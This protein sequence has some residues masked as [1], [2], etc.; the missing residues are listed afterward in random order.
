[1]ALAAL[2][3]YPAERLLMS[4]HPVHPKPVILPAP[5][6]A[7]GVFAFNDDFNG[8]DGMPPDPAHWAYDIGPGA[9]V[10]GNHE[11]ETYTSSTANAYQD[12][13]SHL[14]IAVTADGSGGTDSARIK[15]LGKYTQLHGSWQ[16]SIAIE[17]TPGCWP[18]FWL[19][20]ANGQWPACGEADVMENYGSGFTEG[21]IW[22]S[23]ATQ[24]A[25]GRALTAVDRGFHT[26]Q[27]DSSPGKITY[28]VD[29]TAYAQATSATVRPWP[30][31]GNG[32]LY[33]ILNVAVNGTG[34]GGITPAVSAL[35]V[36]MKVDF[37]R[38]WKS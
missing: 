34:T 18:A 9:E 15:T 23:R 4:H 35:P 17:N 33:A 26:Y 32:G 38:A 24:S 31:D 8:R 21:T 30:F 25:T 6:P 11:T 36:V 12:G 27:V 10:G 16:A 14:V 7:N 22:N 19:M 20:G 3:S 29:G 5:L 37:V 1:M 2:A 13:N 28:F